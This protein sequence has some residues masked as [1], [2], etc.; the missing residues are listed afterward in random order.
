ML[1]NLSATRGPG[2]RK[3]SEGQIL[4]ILPL[5]ELSRDE[6]SG[7]RSSGFRLNGRVVSNS[8]WLLAADNQDRSV[9]S[10]NDGIRYRRSKHS[11]PKMSVMRS[12]HDDVGVES[13]G[14][15]ADYI[16]GITAFGNYESVR[17]TESVSEGA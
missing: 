1:E 7:G 13:V 4:V 10:P 16:H 6:N 5:P 14:D 9:R 11:L 3:V 17:P 2:P 15:S 8:R 12:D